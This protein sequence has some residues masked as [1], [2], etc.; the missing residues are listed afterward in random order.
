M[1][2]PGG[3]DGGQRILRVTRRTGVVAAAGAWLSGCSAAG[4]LNALVPGDT[5]A[6][7]EGL[8]Y[9]PDPRHR[10]DVYKPL[11]PAPGAGPPPVCVFFYGGGWRHGRRADYRF[12]GEAL[13]SRGAIAVVADYR[14]SPEVRYPVFLQDC[15]GAV[16]WTFDHVDELGGAPSSVFLMG[17]SA[18]AYN[19]AMLALDARW[20]RSAGLGD[21]RALAGWIGLAGPYDFL[22][23]ENRQTQ[24]AFGWPDTPRDSQPIEHVTARAPRALLVAAVKDDVVNPQ[25]SSVGLAVQLRAA[26]VP[27][28]LRLYE[29]VNHITLLAALAGPLDWLAPV[30]A[31][32]LAFLGLRAS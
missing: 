3:G 19:A 10:L 29:R 18:G 8:A 28:T 25:R 30:R 7:Q 15:A 13:A 31:D 1:A 24:V 27:I 4:V 9:G 6:V 23:I 17:H 5:Y 11:S 2:D 22:P 32:V 12:V 26:G 21:D 20:L 16:R 14:L